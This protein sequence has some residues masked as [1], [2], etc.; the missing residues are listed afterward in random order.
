MTH[1]WAR[2]SGAEMT[3]RQVGILFGFV[4]GRC[5]YGEG[6]DEENTTGAWSESLRLK[7]LVLT[8]GH[9]THVPPTSPRSANSC[10]DNPEPCLDNNAAVSR[11]QA[12]PSWLALSFDTLIYHSA[13]SEPPAPQPAT[14][15]SLPVAD[16]D[17]PPIIPLAPI[18]NAVAKTRRAG[19]RIQ[20]HSS[21]VFEFRTDGDGVC[22]SRRGRPGL[23]VDRGITDRRSAAFA[24]V[25]PGHHRRII[26][27]P[28]EMTL[29]RRIHPDV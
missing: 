14:D 28:R 16:A 25:S 7:P 19:V 10:A 4:V 22:Y 26:S 21:I 15:I 18:G 24:L 9:L 11:S 2:A 8:F 12:R 23:A 3:T 27:P 1:V 17:R 6:G 20:G 29:T 13:A 5:R